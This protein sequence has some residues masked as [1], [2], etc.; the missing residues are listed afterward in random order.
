MVVFSFWET[1]DLKRF[2]ICVD[3]RIFGCGEG[4]AAGG[5]TLGTLVVSF[6]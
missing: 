5:L 1:I 2:Q 6:E 3:T 4:V